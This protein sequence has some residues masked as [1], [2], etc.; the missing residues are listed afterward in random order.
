M[1]VLLPSLHETNLHANGHSAPRTDLKPPA[2]PRRFTIGRLLR[3][4]TGLGFLGFSTWLLVPLFWN[5]TS[6]QAVINAPVMMLHS[7][8]EGIVTFPCRASGVCAAGEPLLDVD[9]TLLDDS[10]LQKLRAEATALSKRAAALQVQGDV[11]KGLER[12]LAADARHYQEASVR[13]VSRD[14]EQAQAA[15]AVAEE[16]NKQKTYEKDQADR[17]VNSRSISHLESVT[18]RHAAESARHSVAQAR[19][20]A[21][22]LQDQLDDLRRGVYVSEGDG[23]AD[24]PYSQ[25]RLHEVLLKRAE[26]EVQLR[27]VTARADE[28]NSQAAAEEARLRRRGHFALAAPTDGLVW[29]RH[30]TTGSAVLP[31]TGL[32]Q[33][34][35][36]NEVIVDAVIPERYLTDLH[37]GDKVRIR[38]VGSRADLPGQV[39][40]VMGRTPA[41]DDKLLAA[42][43]PLAGRHE[44]HVAIAFEKGPPSIDLLDNGIG[45]PVE[46]VFGDRLGYIR[47]IWEELLP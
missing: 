23:R 16:Q 17:L 24:V 26:I 2:S 6:T 29:R 14:L 32:L 7:P 10:A 37:P 47:R 21:A 31:D 27:D 28:A 42:E 13:R 38:L 33:F 40:Q 1:T 30:V 5:V 41:W 19:L 44:I 45:R 8:I 12:Q 3:R 11:L 46:V 36:R 25:Q 9:N 18:A 4:L 39:K 15:L 34:I 22:R 20:G 35:D 43:P